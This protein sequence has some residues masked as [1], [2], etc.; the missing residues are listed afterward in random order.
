MP[1][2]T[3]SRSIEIFTRIH[4]LFWTSKVPGQDTPNIAEIDNAVLLSDPIGK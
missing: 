2:S 3:P 1:P 4:Y